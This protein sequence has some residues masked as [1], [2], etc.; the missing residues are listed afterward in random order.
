MRRLPW[1]SRLRRLPRLPR[2][3]LWWLR[4][5]RSLL[6]IVGYLPLLLKPGHTQITLK[7]RDVMAGSDEVDPA[8]SCLLCGIAISVW[9]CYG[10]SWQWRRV[11]SLIEKC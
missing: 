3:R 10:S 4:R 2:L 8:K 11:F 6:C 7:M 9:H 1:L 5:R